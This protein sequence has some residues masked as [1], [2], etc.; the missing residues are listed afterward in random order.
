LP[1]ALDPHDVIIAAGK[2]CDL[3]GLARLS[4]ADPK[5]SD[6]NIDPKLG[7][8]PFSWSSYIHGAYRA[9]EIIQPY[10]F[11]IDGSLPSVYSHRNQIGCWR[12]VFRRVDMC[13]SCRDHSFEKRYMYKGRVSPKEYRGRAHRRDG[14]NYI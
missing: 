14:L 4:N 8:G 6:T 10:N 13:F 3:G 2:S 9:L 12:F 1:M 5:Y 11:Y 7:L